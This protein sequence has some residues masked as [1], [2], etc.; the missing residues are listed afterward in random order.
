MRGAVL[1]AAMVTATRPVGGHSDHQ[2]VSMVRAGDDRAFEE[3]YDRYRRRITAYV[4][5]MVS[6]HGRAED[7]TQEVFVS[8]LRRMRETE[9]PIAF[10][11]WV[12]EIAKNAC[13]DAFRRR[14]R[15]EE[16]P[17]HDDGLGGGEELRLVSSTPAPD[18][19]V[20]AKQRLDYLC[21]AFGGLSEV[22]HQILVLRELEGLSYRE[23]GE[24][25]GLSRPAVESTLF[26]AR[27]RL[28]QEYDELAS[29]ARCARVQEIISSAAT[30][31]LSGRDRRRMARHVAACQDCRRHARSLGVSTHPAVRGARRIAALLPLPLLGRRRGDSVAAHAHGSGLMTQVSNVLPAAEPLA[32]SWGKA[33]AT[34]ATLALAGFGAGSAAQHAGP[35]DIGGGGEKAASVHGLAGHLSSAAA[36]ATAGLRQSAVPGVAE[37]VRSATAGGPGA[38]AGTGESSGGGHD[39]HGGAGGGFGSERTAGSGVGASS[40]RADAGGAGGGA[41]VPDLPKQEL[42]SAQRPDAPSAE[43]P[44]APTPPR[45]ESLDLNI[46]PPKA[47]SPPDANSPSAPSAPDTPTAPESPS[48][49]VSAPKAPSTPDTSTATDTPKSLPSVP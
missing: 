18:A 22:H 30:G 11:P 27:R 23:I 9:R 4:Y 14:G 12:Y 28:T 1:E 36:A 25:M 38:P 29:G 24:R 20:E 7:I 47:P 8:A 44:D 3:L 37:Q 19:V 46:A 17:I 45:T 13:I 15:S 35:L 48:T 49:S 6:D 33:A 42:P 41:G 21:G 39:E 43:A 31:A 16:V 32:G 10:R 5:G 40:E 34:L 2:L 26:R